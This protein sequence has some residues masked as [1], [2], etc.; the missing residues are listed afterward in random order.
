MLKGLAFSQRR[1]EVWSGLTYWKWKDISHSSA[2]QYSEPTGGCILIDG[3][4]I[5]TIGLNDLCSK[6]SIVAQEPTLFDGTVRSD[7]DPL[8]EHN[9]AI[10]WEVLFHLHM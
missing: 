8:G 10:I 2:F 9:D 7:L 3:I 1:G 4:N 5:T 6:L